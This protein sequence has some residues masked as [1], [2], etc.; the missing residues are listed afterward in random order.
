M[1]KMIPKT[2]NVLSCIFYYMVTP[3]IFALLS[4]VESGAPLIDANSSRVPKV[5]D[6]KKSNKKRSK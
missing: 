5:V 3:S 2:Q 6:Q 1:S 4:E